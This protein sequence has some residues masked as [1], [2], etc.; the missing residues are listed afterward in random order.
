M[1]S[2]QIKLSWPV[3]IVFSSSLQWLSLQLLHFKRSFSIVLP[4]KLPRCCIKQTNKMLLFCSLFFCISEPLEQG[5]TM[6][7]RPIKCYIQSNMHPQLHTITNKNNEHTW[8]ASGLNVVYAY[9]TAWRRHCT[10]V[11]KSLVCFAQ[12][13]LRMIDL[14]SSNF[15]LTNS[16]FWENF[17]FIW[18]NASLFYQL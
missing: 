5:R 12:C 7:R 2:N 13:A 16:L 17:V 11:S 6:H 15:F 4:A 9:F 18:K 3:K 10:I 14:K 1:N 8:L